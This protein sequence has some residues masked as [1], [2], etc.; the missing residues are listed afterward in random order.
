M[1][2]SSAGFSQG[3]TPLVKEGATWINVTSQWSWVHNQNF[4]AV[5]KLFIYDSTEINGVTYRYLFIESDSASNSMDYQTADL[6]RE[7]TSGK[8]FLITRWELTNSDSTEILLYDFGIDVDDTIYPE[9]YG[10]GYDTSGLIL[11]SISNIVISGQSRK[12]YHLRREK[13][14]IFFYDDLWIEG[15]GSMRYGFYSFNMDL[16]TEPHTFESID[17]FWDD[18]IYWRVDS[19]R[20]CQVLN[21]ERLP[22]T[23]DALQVFPNPVVDKLNF[24]R[25]KRIRSYQLF[26][27]NG[28]IC[29][30][31][32]ITYTSSQIDC[33]E[34]SPGMYFLRVRGEDDEIWDFRVMKE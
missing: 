30:E 5:E 10:L 15:I 21:V 18:E 22:K 14:L 26:D 34:L 8:V 25:N 27:V 6:I 29:L 16:G 4:S 24:S 20:S 12:V 3:Y 7:D 2:I 17:C 9:R 32:E 28:Q 1:T 13:S 23:N 31:G 11:D 33:T 19:S